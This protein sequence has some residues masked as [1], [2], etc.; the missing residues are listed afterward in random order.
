MRVLVTGITGFVGVYLLEHLVAQGDHVAGLSRSGQWL[1]GVQPSEGFA[2]LEALDLADAESTPALCDLLLRKQPEVIYHLAAQANP[3]K[4]VT[5]P[6]GTWALNLGGTLNLL[7][8]VRLATL[9][10]PGSFAP[11]IVIVGSGVSYG[12]PRPEHLPVTELCPLRPTNPYGASKAAADLLGIQHAL[13][14]ACNVVVARPF[15][16]AGPRQ[17][18]NYVL[19]SLAQQVAEVEVGLKSTVAVGNLE[20]TRDFTDVRDIV[21]AYR[22]L[23]LGGTAGEIY[24]IGTGRCVKLGEMLDILRSLATVPIPVRTDPARL[25]SVDQPLLLADASKLRAATGWQPAYTIE[26]TLSDM[27]ASA[28]DSIK[29]A[30]SAEQAAP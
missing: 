15:N 18:T 25:R 13:G 2:R 7:E 30:S 6:R 24:N 10:R 20:V 12:N 8:A 5:D 21:Q 11:R 14:D 26:Q 22:L 17:G 1:H 16:H 19:A 3:Q 29:H 28:R 4:S 9:S 23:A 27:L